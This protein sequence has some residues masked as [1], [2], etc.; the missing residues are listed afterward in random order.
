MHLPALAPPSSEVFCNGQFE[1]ETQHD[2]HIDFTINAVGRADS[3]ATVRQPV[4]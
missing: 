4:T 2:L 3:V 1:L